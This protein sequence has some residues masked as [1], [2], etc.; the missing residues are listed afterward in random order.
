MQRYKERY[1]TACKFTAAI[2][3]ST[4]FLHFVENAKAISPPP[5]KAYSFN[6]KQIIKTVPE[7]GGKSTFIV[8][9]K[10]LG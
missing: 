9:D 4:I 2:Y 8:Y 1:K 3:K 6:N 5:N 7:E 10:P